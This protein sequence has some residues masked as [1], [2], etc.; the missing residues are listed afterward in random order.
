MYWTLPATGN[1]IVKTH[2]EILSSML[3]YLY[4]LQT[5][6]ISKLASVYYVLHALMLS[7]V[8]GIVLK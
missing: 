1:L 3:D 5:V 6:N 7:I 8:A 4:K 2:N